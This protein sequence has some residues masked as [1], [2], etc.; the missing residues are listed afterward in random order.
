MRLIL[1]LG[2]L[3]RLVYLIPTMTSS[4]SKLR[5]RDKMVGCRTFRHWRS[6]GQCH[7]GCSFSL[8]SCFLNTYL[9]HFFCT[10][11]NLGPVQ[12]ASAPCFTISGNESSGGGVSLSARSAEWLP[13]GTVQVWELWVR[14]FL[15]VEWLCDC[16]LDFATLVRVY[17][18]EEV[19]T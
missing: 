12:V 9:F 13:Y 19:C 11:L 3:A 17:A 5:V 2:V 15:Y 8:F 16:F 14:T 6:G 7:F 4:W 10:S 18:A 1:G